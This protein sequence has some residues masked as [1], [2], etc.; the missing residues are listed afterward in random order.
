MIF[1]SQRTALLFL[2]LAFP[3]RSQRVFTFFGLLVQLHT[4]RGALWIF[5][6][7]PHCFLISLEFCCCCR[8]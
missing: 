5:A 6:A 7:V 3:L 2:L 8:G 1:F 4:G